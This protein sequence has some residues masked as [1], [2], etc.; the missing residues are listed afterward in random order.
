M[1]WKR[2]KQ[3]LSNLQTRFFTIKKNIR[4]SIVNMGKNIRGAG[5]RGGCRGGTRRYP[6]RS[7][8]LRKSY[9]ETRR[10]P[11]EWKDSI[12]QEYRN[13]YK[14]RNAP[15]RK[16][17]L[18]GKTDEQRTTMTRQYH[19]SM[20]YAPEPIPYGKSITPLSSRLRNQYIHASNKIMVE[21][22]LSEDIQNRVARYI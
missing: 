19:E 16:Q 6:L 20:K 21:N 7:K 15:Y 1:L 9:K 8:S 3:S 2:I 22:D 10:I 14:N 4:L 11:R 12:S 13:V 5:T 17:P 18:N